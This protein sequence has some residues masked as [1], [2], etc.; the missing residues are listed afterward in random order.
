MAYLPI[1]DFDHDLNI[2]MANILPGLLGPKGH[3]GR[4]LLLPFSATLS[5]TT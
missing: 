3:L 2:L 5:T 1:R 4:S